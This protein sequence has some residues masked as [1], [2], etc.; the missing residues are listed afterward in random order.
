MRRR[1]RAAEPRDAVAVQARAIDHLLGGKLARRGFDDRA[2]RVAA[3]APSL[4]HP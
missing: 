3:N 2:V 1:L 4:A